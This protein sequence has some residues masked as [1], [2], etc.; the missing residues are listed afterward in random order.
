MMGFEGRGRR[1][2]CKEG[3]HELSSVV[4]SLCTLS[5]GVVSV[6]K[7]YDKRIE[8]NRYRI[9]DLSDISN[10]YWIFSLSIRYI[11]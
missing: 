11:Y 3:G 5:I 8:I 10:K 2:G 6:A 1:V 4:V 9:P 7:N